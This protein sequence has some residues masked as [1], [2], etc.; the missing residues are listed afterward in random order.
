MTM[1]EA[2]I[3]AGLTK[4]DDGDEFP[5]VR[6][7]FTRRDDEDVYLEIAGYELS[8]EPVVIELEG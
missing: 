2:M 4:A 7:E 5:K 8:Q 6:V 1:K 3:S